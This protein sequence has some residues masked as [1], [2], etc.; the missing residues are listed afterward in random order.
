MI[1]AAVYVALIIVVFS[2][3]RTFREKETIQEPQSRV[4][5]VSVQQVVRQNEIRVPI[6]LSGPVRGKQSTLIRSLVQGTVQWLA[7][8]GSAVSKGSP[9]FRLS[10][11]SIETSY[12]N[13]LNSLSNAQSNLV[14]TQASA[15]AARAQAELRLSQ[16]ETNYELAK[17]A[18]EDAKTTAE[19]SSKQAGD[20][21]RL[22]Y[23]SAYAVTEQ[24]L[25][26][27]G[28]PNLDRYVYEDVISNDITIL[29]QIR[30]VFFSAKP[31]FLALPRAPQ[32]DLL[33]Q[34]KQLAQTFNKVKELNSMSWTF[35]RLAVPSKSFSQDAIDAAI[36][37]A[38]AFATQLTN[39][40]S[41]L[42]SAINGL[43]NTE[44]Q[45][46]IKIA[47]LQKQ[48]EIAELQLANAKTALDSQV[49]ASQ[50]QKLG[51][52]T[53]VSTVSSQ[54]AAARFQF[55]NLSLPAPFAGTVIAHKVTLGSQVSPGQEMVE[56]GNLQI[57]EIG[58]E[59]GSAVAEGLVLGQSVSINGEPVGRIAEIEAAA[60]P[61]TGK[62]GVKIEADNSTGRFIPGSLADVEF[63][64]VYK[65]PGIIAV[66]LSQVRVGQN[67]K[68]ILVVEAGKVVE[69]KIRIGR[70]FG[71]LVE[72]TEGLQ[73]GD[74]IIVENGEFLKEGDKV[75]IRR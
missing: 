41:Q 56:I 47:N 71:E 30:D 27:W 60:D 2:V 5:G 52:S 28:G 68:T 3:A 65:V 43:E 58:V 18:L 59:V 42:K 34:L 38:S 45:N 67:S 23:D 1:E 50:M 74:K 25:R 70:V 15:D 17:Q 12:F 21:A 48:L 22:A 37:Q 75:E 39:V 9:L 7:P 53:Q 24:V 49:A 8:V 36:A 54:V 13:A 20:A 66:P 6:K 19:L 33:G 14:Q 73:E 55:E 29:S 57:V 10:N 4:A 40:D 69:R 61:A 26:F 63:E 35:L 11:S 16:A 62:V 72:V 44:T 64:L 51:A 31:E 32:S 46:Q